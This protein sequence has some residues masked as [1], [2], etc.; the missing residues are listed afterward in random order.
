MHVGLGD[1]DIMQPHDGIDL[2]G[3][4]L[5]ALAHDLPVNL[6]LRRHVDNQVAA[7]LRLTA[8]PPP[9]LQRPALVDIALLDRV[10]GARVIGAGNDGVFGELAFGDVDLTARADAAPAAH[11]IE[12]DAELSRGFQDRH[13]VL[14]FAALARGREDDQMLAQSINSARDGDLRGGLRLRPA[15]RDRRGSSWRNWGHAPSPHRRRGSPA[16]PRDAAG[17]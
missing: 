4:R 7:D 13:A 10:P 2:D 8:E 6:A 12:I 17:S 3:V 1:L 14:E 5:G 9:R 15:A 11:G 16:G